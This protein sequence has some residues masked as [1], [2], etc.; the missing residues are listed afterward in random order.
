MSQATL[1]NADLTSAIL[2]RTILNSADLRQVTLQGAVCESAQF[3]E[4]KLGTATFYKADLTDANFYKADAI[5]VDFSQA[6]LTGA[7][8]EN[9]NINSATSLKDVV[10]DYVYLRENN[11]ERRPHGGGFQPG[12][13]TQRFQQFLD[14]VDLFFVDGV[15]WKAFLTSFQ[16]LQTQYGDENIAVQGIERKGQ[17]SFEVRLAVSSDSDKAE[18]EQTAYERY[19]TNLKQLESQFREQL[20][21]R[22]DEITTYRQRTDSLK[23]ELL[24]AYRQ[25]SR[26]PGTDMMEVIKVLAARPINPVINVES[27]AVADQ[28]SG[29]NDL[30]NAQFA[31]GYA[32]NVQRD[33]VGGT[34]NNYGASFNDITR[35]ITT[36]RDQAQTFPSEH[37]DDVLME[38][39]DLETDVQKPQPDQNRIGRRLKRLAAVATTIGAIAGGAATVSGDLND[40]TGNV[41]ELTETLGIPIEQVQSD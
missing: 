31:G 36:L 11:Q 5:G 28:S 27:S 25:Q 23:D 13:F 10:C 29:K 22:D 18:I 15:N 20:A 37:K 39:E 24:E 38:L 6:V 41:I 21:A 34:I 16:E 35:L 19:E 40:F 17:S 32:E 33:Q 8:I 30:R 14:T 2:F 4:T 3:T 12:E 26:Q 1:C 9:W 7:C